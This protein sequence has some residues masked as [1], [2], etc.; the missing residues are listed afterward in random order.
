MTA[1]LAHTHYLPIT[2][3]G[4]AHTSHVREHFG[5][6]FQLRAFHILSELVS[7]ITAPFILMFYIRPRAL[8][9][10]DFFRNFTVSVV[11][12]GDVCSFAQMDV[13]KHGNP[14]WQPTHSTVGDL[15]ESVN[16]PHC[17]TNQ[18]TQGEHGKTELS[19][20]HFCAYQSG[21]ENARRRKDIRQWT[22]K[23]CT[24]GFR[25][26]TNHGHSEHC[27]GT[28]FVLGWQSGRSVFVNCR[29]A[30]ATSAVWWRRRC[31]RYEHGLL[32]ALA[33]ASQY[34]SERIAAARVHAWI[35]FSA[36]VAA[37]V[38]RGR[39]HTVP[40]HTAQY[41]GERNGRKWTG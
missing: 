37:A 27:N 6:F 7:P 19:L 17:E 1:V 2:W 41:S 36:Y 34:I 12:V 21:L 25:A 32:T 3:K 4:Q 35:R 9:Y 8:D 22:E 40:Q 29:I 10:V 18:Y 20:V 31:R 23:A 30:D 16:T 11:G 38:V 13:R 14:D 24:A 15:T 33:D 26:H 28:E 39:F 5:Q